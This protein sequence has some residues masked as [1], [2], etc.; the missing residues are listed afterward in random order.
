MVMRCCGHHHTT[1]T[2]SL[3]N[4]CGLGSKALNDNNERLSKQFTRLQTEEGNIYVNKVVENCYRRTVSHWNMTTNLCRLTRN[5]RW[6]TPMKMPKKDMRERM[7]APAPS[8]VAVLEIMMSF[9]CKRKERQGHSS[10]NKV[11]RHGQRIG[12]GVSVKSCTIISIVETHFWR[13]WQ[14]CLLFEWMVVG[15][16]L[17]NISIPLNRWK[18]FF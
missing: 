9:L 5:P 10:T 18:K 14:L 15:Y 2:C 13:N 11:K 6:A 17:F 1:V 3:L 4:L 7:R 8:Q 12:H 16:T